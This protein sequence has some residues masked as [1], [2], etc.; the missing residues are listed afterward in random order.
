MGGEFFHASGGAR[1]AHDAGLI[2][3]C[4]KERMHESD[5]TDFCGGGTATR[6]CDLRT[7]AAAEY[8]RGCIVCSENRAGVGA[9]QRDF[10]RDHESQR[11]E[12]EWIVTASDPCNMSQTGGGQTTH[13]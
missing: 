5:I 10:A 6:R 7:G 3:D 1:R 11:G 12:C 2:D 8:H 4:N 13:R 9:V